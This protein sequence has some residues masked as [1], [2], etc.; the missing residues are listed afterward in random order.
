VGKLERP[1]LPL[2]CVTCRPEAIL[3][4]FLKNFLRRR[5]FSENEHKKRVAA[6]DTNR[7]ALKWRIEMI[8]EKT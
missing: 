5:F 6:G 7:Y 2:H 3:A 4:D 1:Y 8:A